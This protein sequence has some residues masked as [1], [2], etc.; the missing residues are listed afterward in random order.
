MG[1]SILRAIRSNRALI[2]AQ[3]RNLPK[4]LLPSV[5]GCLT[6]VSFDDPIYPMLCLAGYRMTVPYRSTEIVW[7]ALLG[8]LHDR[9]PILS[10]LITLGW[11]PMA[12]CIYK[13]ISCA[14][15]HPFVLQ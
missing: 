12:P 15:G 1:G 13:G 5:L 4:D 11:R 9:L 10:A 6:L 2:I 7:N 14:I 3:S 8:K